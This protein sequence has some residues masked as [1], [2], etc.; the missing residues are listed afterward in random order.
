VR[1][2]NKK[3]P[4]KT[5]KNRA[6]LKGAFQM[7]MNTQHISTHDKHPDHPA[8]IICARTHLI[9]RAMRRKQDTYLPRMNRSALAF[10]RV[11]KLKRK[12]PPSC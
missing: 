4:P 11:K 7:G 2:N 12:K 6:S 5:P 8:M 3:K 1:K 9:N 10:E